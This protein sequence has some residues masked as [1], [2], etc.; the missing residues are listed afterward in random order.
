ML[1]AVFRFDVDPLALVLRGT[2]LYWFLFLVFRFVLRRDIGALGIADV[3][4]LVLVADAS[5]NAMAGSYTSVPEGVLLVATLI[6]WNLLLDWA[7]FRWEWA[8]RLAEPAP[9]LL[10]R[11]GRLIARNLRREFITPDEVLGHLRE[12]GVDDIRGVRAAYL[13]S[14]GQFSVLL[15]NGKPPAGPQQTQRHPV[16]GR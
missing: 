3:L 15:R 14:D 1:D 4:L 13:E 8:R 10:V 6:G 9:L 16:A 5:Q 2:L 12:H 7:G 11:N